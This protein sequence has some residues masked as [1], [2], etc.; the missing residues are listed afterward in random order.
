VA[1]GAA[2][3]AAGFFQGFSVSSSSSRTPVAEAAGAR[4]QLTGLVG[5]LAI[6][7][8]LLFFPN[9]V[10]NLPDSALAAVVISAAIGLIEAAGV[11]KLYRVHRTEFAISMACFLGV[12]VVG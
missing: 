7:L 5:A 6:A 2:N 11:R 12:A 9:L 4:T 10:Q 1:L 8:L 3:L